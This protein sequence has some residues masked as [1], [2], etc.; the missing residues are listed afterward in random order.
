MKKYL[1][2]GMAA[3]AMCA[4]FTSCSKDTD[5]T[6]VYNDNKSKEYADK[7]VETFGVTI[8]PENDWGFG[9][10]TRAGEA[11]WTRA[12][13]TS[14]NMWAQSYVIPADPEKND[15]QLFGGPPFFPSRQK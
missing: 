2:T 6:D 15:P 4:A 13:N 12:I 9:T 7:F 5:F 3:L 1:M 11:V 8:D 10:T 14:A